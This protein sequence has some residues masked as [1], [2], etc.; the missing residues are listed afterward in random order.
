MVGAEQD[1][2]REKEQEVSIIFRHL[3]ERSNWKDECLICL[4]IYFYIYI[5]EHNNNNN[6]N[7]NNNNNITAGFQ[8][9]AGC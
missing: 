7:I 4:E 2:E 5:F 8:H 6:A 9:C 1:K 3:S